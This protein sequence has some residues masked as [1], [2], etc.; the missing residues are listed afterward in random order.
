MNLKEAKNELMKLNN[1]LKY[2]L[3]RKEIEFEKT[4]YKPIT[5][6]DILV[7]GGVVSNQFDN[8]VI[9][10]EKYDDIIIGIEEE[11]LAVQT[12]ILSEIKRMIKYDEIPLIEYLRDTEQMSWKEIDKLLCRSNDYSR[13]KYS[14]YKNSNDTICSV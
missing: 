10:N 9:K 7:Q 8:F 12:F 2:Y 3:K 5:I 4:T 14:R 13:I 1:K 6:K 11:I